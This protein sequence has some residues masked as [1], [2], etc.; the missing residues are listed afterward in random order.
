M[1][2]PEAPAPPGPGRALRRRYTTADLGVFTPE[3]ARRFVPEG[4]EDP[5]HDVVLAW[6]LL[7]R[8]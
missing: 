1:T 3:E 8:L 2:G 6:E 5:Q 7:Y 4:N